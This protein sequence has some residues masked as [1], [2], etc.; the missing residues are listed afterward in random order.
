MADWTTI[1]DAALGEDAPIR[2]VDVLALRDNPV[3]AMQGAAGAPRIQPQAFNA[4]LSS[5]TVRRFYLTTTFGTSSTSFQPVFN[6]SFS[7]AG[8][9]QVR[10]EHFRTPN[11][12][13]SIRSNARLLID[14]VVI[15]DNNNN[16]GSPALR[17]AVVTVSVNSRIRIEHRRNDNI[18]SAAESLLRNIELRT[19]GGWLWLWPDGMVFPT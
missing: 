18:Q 11:T 13:S 6:Y 9:V 10:Y 2:S 5:G 7:Q 17:E 12:G 15:L 16:D 14:N 4:P 19:S 1:P 3:A 8:T